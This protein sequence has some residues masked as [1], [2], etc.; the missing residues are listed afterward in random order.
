MICLAILTEV[1]ELYPLLQV[2]VW[3]NLFVGV[4]FTYLILPIKMHMAYD[5]YPAVILSQ[6]MVLSWLDFDDWNNWPLVTMSSKHG[7]E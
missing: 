7:Y 5:M 2:F 6:A 4:L 1:L 3:G